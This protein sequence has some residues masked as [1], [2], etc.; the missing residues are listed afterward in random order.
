M[1]K[2]IA[3]CRDTSREYVPIACADTEKEILKAAT[4]FKIDHRH[5]YSWRLRTISYIQIPYYCP[6]ITKQNG[7]KSYDRHLHRIS[8]T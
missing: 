4:Q 2:W 5:D 6:N 3:L 8:K 7:V 1:K